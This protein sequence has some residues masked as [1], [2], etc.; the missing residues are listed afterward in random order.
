MVNEA[1]RLVA[2]AG[3]VAAVGISQ[4]GSAPEASAQPAN[5]QPQ[6]AGQNQPQY[7]YQN[8][9]QYQQGQYQQGQ[10]QPAQVQQGQAPIASV[11]PGANAFL[12]APAGMEPAEFIKQLAGQKREG[13]EGGDA[14]E[15]KKF[16]EVSKGYEKVISTAD[17]AQSL[18][19]LWVRNKDGQMLAELPRGWEG[20]K[21][22]FAMT[23]ASGEEYA[24]LQAGDMY[25]YWKRFDNRLMLIVPNLE[26]RSTGDQESKSSVKRLFTDRVLLDIAILSTGPNG[27]PVIDM[28]DL[29]VDQ[30]EK[31]FGSD[32]RGSQKSLARIET[33][34]AFP[35]NIEAAW[36]MP[37]AGGT[38]KTFHYSISLLPENTGYQPRVADE[39]VGYFTTVFRDLGK[40]TDE[41]KWIRYIN[42]WNLEKA[43]PKLKISPA[44]QP[45]VFYIESTVP[46]RYRRF[47]QEGAE[48]WNEAF[49]KIGIDNAIVVYQQDETTGAHMDKDPEDVRYNF[50]RWLSNDIGTAIG[51]SRVHPL[52]GQILDAD[53][54]LTDGWIRYFWYNYN[55]VLPEMLMEGYSPETMAWLETRPQYDPR[56]LLAAPE[57]RD[58]LI[59]ERHRRGVTAYGGHPIALMNTKSDSAL[60]MGTSEYDGLLGRMSQVN[61]LCMAARGKG[62]DLAVMRMGLEM[63]E[64]LFDDQTQPA[65][66]AGGKKEEGKDDKKKDEKKYDRLD[67]IPDWFVG[68]L[69]KDLVAHEVG[70]TIGLRHNFKASSIYTF[71]Q[72]NSPE[73]KDKKPQTGSVMDYTPINMIVEKDGQKNHGNYGQTVIGPYDLWV[74]EYGYTLGDPKETLKRTSEPELAYGTDED[75]WGPDPL[76]RRYDFAANP[77]S[78]AK[79]RVELAKYHRSRLLDKFVKDGQSWAKARRGYN[80]TLGMQV[81]AASMMAN[82]VGTA[83]VNRDRKGDPNGRD[84][85]VVVPAEQQ[86]EA[87]KFVI[88]TIFRDE[89]FGLSPDLLRKMTTDRWLDNGGFAE[90]MED[91][92]FPIHDRISGLQAS[93]LTTLMNPT[94]LRRVYDNEF[95]TPSDQDAFTLPEMLDTLTNEIFSETGQSGGKKFTARQP[96]ISTLRQNL[97]REYV[98]R[99]IDLTLP[100]AGSGAAFKP[101]SN[102]AMQKLREVRDRVSKFVDEKG[103]PS[104]DLDSYTGAHFADLRSRIERSLN[105]QYIYNQP[106]YGFDFGS[107]FFFGQNPDGRSGQNGV[108]QPGVNR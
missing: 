94:R 46:V 65:D 44:K 15:L 23:V 76:I 50:I 1:A 3:L 81:G 9:P 106:S 60:M 78:Y 63:S 6:Y 42:R 17:G 38:L 86:R 84:P 48:Y 100:G 98:D 54:I 29:L 101:I 37:T 19:T 102:L 75:T 10:I 87:L 49:R 35:Q 13:G 47:V 69:L 40:F 34:K 72:L 61:G 11:P 58:Q 53:V 62:F 18:Y 91:P 25:A 67:G 107:M 108:N 41:E 28:D 8:Q 14:S 51:P 56:I 16:D 92:T 103:K 90:A 77:I 97:Q 80:I 33:A 68:P 24:G 93:S 5:Q 4:F 85:I 7:Q 74:I 95:R 21:H 104:A 52:T 83:H 27:Q 30:I 43:D 71:E 88:E 59:A 96:M 82:W 99:L 55:Q 12:P 89:A 26:T 70:H 57:Q 36:T 105:A 22:F 31:F 64:E 66:E 39:R 45:I 2:V 32:G 20:Q 73:W 79:S